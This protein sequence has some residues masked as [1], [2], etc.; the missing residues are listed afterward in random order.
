MCKAMSIPFLNDMHLFLLDQKMWLRIKY[1]P[2]SERLCSIG[3]HSMA[4]T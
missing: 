2:S 3:N 4:V 1:V